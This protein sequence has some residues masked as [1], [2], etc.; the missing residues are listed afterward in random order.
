MPTVSPPEL[1]THPICQGRCS[2]TYS[3]SLRS[4]SR[5]ITPENSLE[6]APRSPAAKGQDPPLRRHALFQVLDGLID[7][8]PIDAALVIGVPEE[9]A[10]ISE[11]VDD[12][13]NPAGILSD[14]FDRG[15]VEQGHVARAGDP[16]PVADVLV[17]FLRGEGRDLA[18]QPDPLLELPEL[19]EI[20]L[21]LQLGLP[22]QQDLQ[23]F[24][25][26]GLEVR[27]QADLLQRRRVEVLRLVDDEDVF[28][29]AR[30]R[31]MRKLFNAMSRR[32][33]D[34]SGLVIPKSSRTYSRIPSN[35]IVE[36]KT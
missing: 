21:G 30:S 25:G 31:S 4:T 8:L 16:Q 11:D 5:A 32:T 9:E 18:A 3:G 23:E 2:S 12:S 10:V 17:G 22:H 27:E 26:G 20:K 13:W 1:M 15:L 34:S 28:W 6:L 36:W 7:G 14:P 29:P 19:R 35:G 24:A 33:C